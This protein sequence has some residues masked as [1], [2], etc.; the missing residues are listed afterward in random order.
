[1]GRNS[2]G[3]SQ[4][5]DPIATAPAR[6]EEDRVLARSYLTRVAPDLLEVLG[7]AAPAAVIRPPKRD[8]KAWRVDCPECAAP[9][10]QP[11]GTAD[12]ARRTG[13]PRKTVHR[14]RHEMAL[15]KEADA[16]Q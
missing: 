14:S 4:G 6:S 15:Q 3:S 1:V 8:A 2:G 11:C 9:P 13:P 7:L 5:L 10:G 12:Y 16:Q